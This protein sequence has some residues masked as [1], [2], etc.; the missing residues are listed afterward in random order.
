[1]L[2]Y[3]PPFTVPNEKNKATKYE[4]IAYSKFLFY[5]MPQTQQ[6]L[7]DQLHNKSLPTL[8][9]TKET[10]NTKK[11]IPFKTPD[12]QWINSVYF[13]IQIAY[14]RICH[15][16][17][18][19]L[20]IDN[21]ECLAT[22]DPLKKEIISL[23][24]LLYD[25]ILGEIPRA[26]DLQSTMPMLSLLIENVRNLFDAVVCEYLQAIITSFNKLDTQPQ[27]KEFI[28][29]GFIEYITGIKKIIETTDFS[30][31]LG[32]INEQTTL[33]S[34]KFNTKDQ[35][36]AIFFKNYDKMVWQENITPLLIPEHIYWVNRLISGKYA[37]IADPAT[38]MKNRNVKF[39]Q[40]IPLKA[41]Q[42]IHANL[43]DRIKNFKCITHHQQTQK[44]FVQV[45]NDA[46]TLNSDHKVNTGV[47]EFKTNSDQKKQFKNEE[48]INPFV[49]PTLGEEEEEEEEEDFKAIFLT[50]PI[51][52]P[53]IYSAPV[54]LI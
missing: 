4:P 24:Y 23:Y 38:Q 48:Q 53:K 31:F 15:L 49:D 29:N 32:E 33:N 10:I 37:I 26:D 41:I 2:A 19:S 30:T 52:K 12:R 51:M 40:I 45:H 28:Q 21:I 22:L 44:Q 9:Y 11:S 36:L 13:L 6:Q 14:P 46:F 20:I 35:Q 18:L 47:L 16:L 25:K 5:Y 50:Y 43:K 54:F 3:Q 42:K 1:M 8:I 27:I 7:L 34:T 39:D 17:I